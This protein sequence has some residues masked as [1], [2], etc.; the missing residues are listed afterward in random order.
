MVFW[1][2]SRVRTVGRVESLGC[3]DSL[4]NLPCGYG[5]LSGAEDV[6]DE[7]GALAW[8]KPVI[9]PH[10]PLGPDGFGFGFPVQAE[11]GIDVPQV[12]SMLGS[13]LLKVGNDAGNLG[14]LGDKGGYDVS[15]S[16]GTGPGK[17][18]ICWRL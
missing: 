18:V 16:H 7:T 8:R 14:T 1:I 12:G 10:Y 3:H 4:D 5:L 2:I 15:V 11:H 13:A 9:A 17:V 6:I